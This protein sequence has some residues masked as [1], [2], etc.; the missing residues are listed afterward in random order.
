MNTPLV[1][2]IKEAEAYLKNN[3]LEKIV[4]ASRQELDYGINEKLE[5]RVPFKPDLID[6]CRIHQFVIEYKRTT[7][8]EFGTGW[9]SWVFADALSKL[10]A[11]YSH[12]ITTLR[13]NNPFQLHVVDDELE[14]LD[15]A[16]SRIPQ[17]LESFISFY[18][19]PAV[20]GT[21]N[22][23]ICTYYDSLPLI[24][25]DFI[26]VDGPG[27]FNVVG[28]VS[29]WHTRHKDM[30][31]M[32]ADILRI[33]HFLTPG[34]IIV[35]DGR[36]ANARFFKANTQRNWAYQYDA[37]YDQHVYALN[38]SALGKFNQKQLDFYE[39]I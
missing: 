18:E 4:D 39:Q 21:F 32:S 33:E 34:T 31:P 16:K 27:Q 8:L 17:S 20:M 26:Y 13:R 5:T 3:G 1:G 35:F 2:S 38:E 28:E 12:E 10:K 15:I 6:L 30:M 37:L 23:R 24:S 29:G 22:G 36:A 25:P 11:K 9:S 7:I 19:I 14:F